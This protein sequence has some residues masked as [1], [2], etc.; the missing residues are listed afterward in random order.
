M[1]FNILEDLKDAFFGNKRMEELRHFAN[2]K[3][4]QLSRRADPQSLS[5]SLKELDIFTFQKNMTI[6]GLLTKQEPR[7]T[8]T[9]QIFDYYTQHFTTIATTVYLFHTNS[10]QV[11]QFKIEPKGTMKR[12][13]TSGEF[14]HIDKDFSKMYEVT[15]NDMNFMRMNITIQFAE[16]MKKLDGFVLEGNDEFLVLYKQGSLSDIVDM[17]NIYDTGLAF[18]EII[19]D[20]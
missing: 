3:S 7:F 8:V 17:D 16:L 6:K 2:S 12:M 10:L 13:F 20:Y 18:I 1:I 15:S 19:V 11:P 9:G 14:S 5:K 4:F